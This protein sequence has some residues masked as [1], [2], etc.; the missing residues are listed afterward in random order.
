MYIRDIILKLDL[1]TLRS[2]PCHKLIPIRLE[3]KN[4]NKTCQSQ[5][6]KCYIIIVQ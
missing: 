6:N 2:F 3:N 5:Q 1:N 4:K